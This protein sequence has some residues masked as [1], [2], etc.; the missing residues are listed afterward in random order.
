MN[1]SW[2]EF[3]DKWV[4]ICLSTEPADRPRAE[5]AIRGIYTELGYEP[6][7]RIEWARSPRE[8]WIMRAAYAARVVETDESKWCEDF[9]RSSSLS[10]YC[11]PNR[12]RESLVGT[13]LFSMSR[14]EAVLTALK[15][16]AIDFGSK[17]FDRSAIMRY[18]PE[19][20]MP[21]PSKIMARDRPELYDI[22][23]YFTAY[24]GT[25]LRRCG[26]MALSALVRGTTKFVV[27]DDAEQVLA[28]LGGEEWLSRSKFK[29]RDEALRYLGEIVSDISWDFRLYGSVGCWDANQAALY[30]YCR[31]R[32]VCDSYPL[33]EHLVAFC[34]SAVGA[35]ASP[36]VCWLCER[37]AA[38]AVDERGRLHS[39]DGP[40]LT[41][42]DGWSIWAYHGIELWEDAVMRPETIV[43]DTILQCRNVERRR[44]L[45]ELFGLERFV[46]EMET[47][48][49]RCHKDRNG[50]LWKLDR[51]IALVE[52]VN[53]T[54]EPDG[55]YKHYFLPCDPRAKTA[56]EAVAGTYGLRPEQYRVAKRT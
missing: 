27:L 52:V 12:L 55:S 3:A 6:P 7:A 53:G 41:Y 48:G 16:F 44:A 9:V 4:K 30:A 15:Q 50:T 26:V 42:R 31:S 43:F 2:K 11:L 39:T 54:P 13:D 35:T 21:S 22:V 56:T 40:A 33:N 49:Y 25:Y 34:Q 19:F 10:W 23:V 17:L 1:D 47:R 20:P 51:D 18:V 45:I 37:P 29:E 5:A 38:I 28:I 24:L 32:G 8:G 36:T 46:R 14:L